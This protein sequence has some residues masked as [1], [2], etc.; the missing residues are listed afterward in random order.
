MLSPTLCTASHCTCR[1][2]DALPFSPGFPGHSFR[3]WLEWRGA[4]DDLE[5][6][7]Q[8]VSDLP[9]APPKL[10]PGFVQAVLL[11]SAA[12][13]AHIPEIRGSL[14]TLLGNAAVLTALSSVDL[15]SHL[16][17]TDYTKTRPHSSPSNNS[18][19]S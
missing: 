13:Q 8:R 19:Y 7:F 6:L 12:E 14:E 16:L 9:Q 5:V 1:V 3:E 15:V 10:V 2:L 11:M 18:A 4:D 17:G